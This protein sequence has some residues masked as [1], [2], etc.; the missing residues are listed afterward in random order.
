MTRRLFTPQQECLRQL[1]MNVW[2]WRGQVERP[3]LQRRDGDEVL[4]LDLQVNFP[5]DV[6]VVP[7]TKRREAR[8]GADWA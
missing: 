3:E 8:I 4:L 5:G 6:L 1:P 7:F 2:R